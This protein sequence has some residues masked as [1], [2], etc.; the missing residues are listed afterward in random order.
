MLASI[1]DVGPDS[2]ND[3]LP[4]GWEMATAGNLIDLNGLG[5]T[6]FDGDGY[7]DL[8]ELVL[9]IANAA[10]GTDAELTWKSE[11]GLPYDLLASTTLDTD[12]AT[13]SPVAGQTDITPSV[14]DGSVTI[15]SPADPQ[16]F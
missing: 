7:T 5:G 13:W 15:P 3:N 16:S 9:S 6:N 4:D 10:N 8:E 11:A 1:A 12:P 2:D 14:P